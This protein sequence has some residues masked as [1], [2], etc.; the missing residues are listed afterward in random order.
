VKKVMDQ[1]KEVLNRRVN[2]MGVSEASVN[3]E[4]KNRLRVEMPG[5]KDA[6]QAINRIGK[7]GQTPLYTC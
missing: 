6:K 2:A 4:G 7:N 5:V 1:T 3:V